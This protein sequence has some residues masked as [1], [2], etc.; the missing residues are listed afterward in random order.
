MKLSTKVPSPDGGAGFAVSRPGRRSV[1]IE[2]QVAARR[3]PASSGAAWLRWEARPVA[4]GTAF[5][6]GLEIGFQLPSNGG[7]FV[8]STGVTWARRS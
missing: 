7:R 6:A 4:A 5:D 1:S 8:A 3:R 2:R